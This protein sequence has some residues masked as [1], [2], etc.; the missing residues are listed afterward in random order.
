MQQRIN[1]FVISNYADRIRNE[2]IRS[3]VEQV[4]GNGC[5]SE[6]GTPVKGW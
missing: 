6:R 4:S 2:F 1:L 5:T 3:R